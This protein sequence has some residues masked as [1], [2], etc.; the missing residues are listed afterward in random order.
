M[1]ACHSAPL[2]PSRETAGMQ[3]FM[4]RRGPSWEL[5]VYLG[6]HPVTGAKRYATRSVRGPRA[7][8]QRVLRA[9][10]AA[11]EAGATHRAGATFGELCEAWLTNATTQLAAN[12][13][14]ET[15][16]LLDR[17]LLPALGGVTLAALLPEHLDALYRDLLDPGA[18]RKPLSGS[19]VRRIHGVAHRVL[20]VGVRWGWIATNPAAGTM[21]P[22][23]SAARSPHPRP[24]TLPA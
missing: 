23:P 7:D 9:M 10:V 19:T 5:R 15:R 24:L 3:G 22:D 2:P 12:T 14:A 18:D 13:T 21:P 4:R 16:R 17:H 8:A 1:G 20:N 6:R 11:A